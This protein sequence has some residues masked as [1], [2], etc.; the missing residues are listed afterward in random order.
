MPVVACCRCAWWKRKDAT[1]GIC[2]QFSTRV[3]ETETH[4]C[5]EAKV[6]WLSPA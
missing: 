6:V 2:W 3:H 1:S 5:F 4:P